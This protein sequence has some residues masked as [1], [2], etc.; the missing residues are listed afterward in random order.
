MVMHH[1]LREDE[2]FLDSPLLALS[3]GQRGCFQGADVVLVA[4]DS[5]SLGKRKQWKAK[6]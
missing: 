6:A 5:G 3:S 1:F 4:T 2:R